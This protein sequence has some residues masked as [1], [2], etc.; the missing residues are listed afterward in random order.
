MK[1]NWLIL[2]FFGIG[3]M[4]TGL[5]GYGFFKK[6]EKDFQVPGPLTKAQILDIPSGLGILQIG[7]LL[8]EQGIIWDPL[9]FVWMSRW[10]TMVK[11]RTHHKKETLKAGEYEISAKASAKE[12][13][14][15]LLSG[16]V[17]LHKITVSEGMTSAQIMDLLNGLPT[18]SGTLCPDLPEGTLL[19][20]TY[21]FPKGESRQA[22]ITRMKKAQEDFLDP[23][24]TERSPQ[25][26][27]KNK[28]EAIV[29]AS[30]V[31]KETALPQERSRIASV[32]INRLHH[33]MLLQSDPT[34]AYVLH[35]EQGRPLNQGLS[36]EDLKIESPLNTYRHA[37]L[38]P[39]PI[40]N[41]GKASLWAV[42]HPETTTFLYFV[43]DG[44][45]GHVFSSTLTQHV[46][47]HQH[48]RKIRKK[49]KET[50]GS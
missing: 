46:K 38:P 4:L 11:E 34:V 43:A 18:L 29:L 3:I 31:E 44:T 13:Y 15:A 49:L 36:K 7:M 22:L 17:Y 33:Q 41:P 9:P 39:V 37:G 21:L 23:L 50:I 10:H 40:C 25:C 2:W 14:E 28:H 27:F 12:I 45:G 19:P 35:K 1:K 5:V 48:W 24:W 42:F 6:L 32:F 47:N 20:E 8:H 26:G 30:I 16:K